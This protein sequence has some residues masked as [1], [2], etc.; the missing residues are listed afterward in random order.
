MTIHY[1]PPGHGG[2][3]TFFYC[4]NFF[5]VYTQ[6]HLI[7]AAGNDDTKL[8]EFDSL[9][10]VKQVVKYHTESKEEVKIQQESWM[11]ADTIQSKTQEDQITEMIDQELAGEASSSS[12]DEFDEQVAYFNHC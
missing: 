8:D 6:I 2:G 1:S 3:L 11:T 10:N 9:S 7:D 5:S 12:V 4:R